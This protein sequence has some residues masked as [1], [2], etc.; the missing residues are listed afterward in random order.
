[1]SRLF[2]HTPTRTAELLGSEY[3]WL[4][5]LADGPTSTG[6]ASSRCRSTGS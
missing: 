4:R 5:R 6:T 2:W 3:A 1:M